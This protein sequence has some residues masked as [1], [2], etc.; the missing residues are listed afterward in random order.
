MPD[1]S[2]ET[3]I[4]VAY[5][6]G[7]DSHVLLH[8]LA[9]LR[10]QSEFQL[11]AIYVNH[12]L[13]PNAYVWG[14]HCQQVCGELTVP[15][16]QLV[17]DAAPIEGQSPEAVA[18]NARYQAFKDHLA[19]G[20]ILCTAHHQDDQAETLLLQLLRGAGPKGLAA[21]PVTSGLANAQQWRPLLNLSQQQLR[22][23]AKAHSLNWI[24]DE[25]NL[26]TGFARNYL[27]HKVM[28]VLR[29][30]WPSMAA[31]VTR[32]ASHCGEAA[33][34]MEQLALED[35][36]RVK[37]SGGDQLVISELLKLDLA[38][39]KNLLRFWVQ[40]A[41][42]PLPSEKKLQH[43]L[44][45]VIPAAPDA[46][47]CVNWP[48][49]EVR[50]FDN[51]L[52]VMSPVLKVPT[53]LSIEWTDLDIPFMLPNELKVSAKRGRGS[54]AL[55]ES[56]L[57]NQRL[58]IRFRSGSE[59]IQPAGQSFHID[60][61]K[62]FQQQRVLPWQRDWIPLLYVGEQLALVVGYCVDQSFSV[63]KGL[64]VSCVNESSA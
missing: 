17:V 28:P 20:D 39:Q 3:R 61:K 50:R 29:Q 58:T 64:L 6:G 63:K 34:L 57:Q 23:Y 48:G 38:R 21:M 42:L 59:R 47:P 5:S 56:L 10:Q 9:R 22:D 12:G 44:S 62:L 45:D 49:A 14:E 19:T 54:L 46:R 33:K 32:S 51:R 16:E 8:A 27:R 18:R 1:L 30:R 37:A 53:G 25:S 13:S 40:K 55:D 41:G 60:L 52:Y 26:D 11:R 24:E 36:H 35:W 2:P 43:I 4:W 7:C 31:T 15:L